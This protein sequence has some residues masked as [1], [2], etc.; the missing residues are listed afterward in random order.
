MRGRENLEHP[1]NKQGSIPY[2]KEHAMRGRENLEHPRNKQGSIPWRGWKSLSWW[3]H[4][5]VND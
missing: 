3:R 2:R 5:R 1:R 4:L